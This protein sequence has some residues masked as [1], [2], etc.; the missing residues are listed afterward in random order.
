MP[1]TNSVPKPTAVSP[2]NG[3][4]IINADDWGRDRLTTDRIL[5]CCLIGAVS[6][7]S[8][9]VFME[10]LERAAA[11]AREQGIELGLHLNFTTPFSG[12]GVRADLAERQQQIAHYLLRHRLAQI[13]FHPGQ[14]RSFEYVVAAQLDEFRRLYR[15]AP[16]RIDGHHHMHLC[17]NVL[18]QKLLPLGTMAR[19]SFSFERGE[20]SL[21]NYLYRSFVDRSLA[22]RHCLTDYFF[23]LAPLEP[24]SRLRRVFSLASQFTV[25][26][27]THPVNPEEHLYLAGGE[28]FRQ[29]G[30]MRVTRPSVM[31]LRSREAH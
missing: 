29:I 10:D 12:S 5:D 15:A 2:H 13:V 25:E 24:V 27:E 19:R 17:A 16:E 23:S 11:I 30:D 21:G 4:L 18:I 1:P 20:K 26:V 3:L 22:R 8:A 9:M 7:V 31:R 6:S 28:I 14:M